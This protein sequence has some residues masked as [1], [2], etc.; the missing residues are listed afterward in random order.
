MT[1]HILADLVVVVHLLFV[2]Y[3]IFGGLLVL[4]WK[5]TVFLHIPALLW[6]TVVEARGWICPLTPLE[7]RFRMEAGQTG[8]SGGFVD[9]YVVPVLYPENL[10]RTDQLVLA[11]FLVTINVV[12]YVFVIRRLTRRGQPV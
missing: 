11:L 6:G 7:N 1:Y 2:I 3:A 10:T 5:F 12:I 4:K 8:Y 9:N